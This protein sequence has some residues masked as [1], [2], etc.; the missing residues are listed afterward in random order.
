M[1]DTSA[2]PA[3]RIR[4]SAMGLILQEGDDR[5][6]PV[7]VVPEK[8]MKRIMWGPRRTYPTFSQTFLGEGRGRA[9]GWLAV[10]RFTNPTTTKR[11]PGHFRAVGDEVVDRSTLRR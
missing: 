7:G 10:V 1:A 8:K 2:C 3:S 6:G 5:N 9:R 11:R 4:L